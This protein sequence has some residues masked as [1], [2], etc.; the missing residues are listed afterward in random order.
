MSEEK[1]DDKEKQDY[2]DICYICYRTESRAGKMIHIP[3]NIAICSDCMQ[4]TFDTMN[5]GTFGNI[6][7]M[8][9]MNMGANFNMPNNE[10]PSNQKVKKKKKK[11]RR[12]TDKKERG[13]VK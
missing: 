3:N 11:K 6:P 1:I 9:M 5:N 4:K 8:D 2:E 13:E 12:K 10:M 7:Y